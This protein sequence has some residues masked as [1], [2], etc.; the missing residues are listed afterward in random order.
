MFQLTLVSVKK[1][2][3]VTKIREAI[4]SEGMDIAKLAEDLG[5]DDTS[6]NLFSKIMERICNVETRSWVKPLSTMPSESDIQKIIEAA[7]TPVPRERKLK[8]NEY[9]VSE[10]MGDIVITRNENSELVRGSG[11]LRPNQFYRVFYED[12]ATLSAF[13]TK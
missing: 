6:F 13:V 9:D 11:N 3:S 10:L 2:P 7:K 8:S 4:P 1:L 5:V 12:S